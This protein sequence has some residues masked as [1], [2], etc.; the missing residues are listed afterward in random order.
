MPAEFH[1]QVSFSKSLTILKKALSKSID[2]DKGE[3]DSHL[4]F[5][6]LMYREISRVIEAE[7]DVPT[8]APDHLVNSKFTIKE[9]NRIETLIN[10]LTLPSSK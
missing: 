9:L 2:L 1:S 10:G 3:I 7:P 6:G 4:L 5:L 8:K